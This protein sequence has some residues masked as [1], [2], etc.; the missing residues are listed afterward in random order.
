MIPTGYPVPFGGVR[1]DGTEHE[2]CERCGF[3]SRA[4]RRQD[5]SALFSR[6][7]HWWRLATRACSV[8]ELNQRPAPQVWSA[9]E[10]GLHSAMVLPILRGAIEVMLA[11]DRADVH[12]PWPEV[13][14]EDAT[15]PLTLDP[16]PLLDDL[17]REG[18]LFSRLVD[19]SQRGWGHLGH[20]D[21]GTWWQAE[22]TL[23]HA[24]HD[25]THH[26]LDVLEGLERIRAGVEERC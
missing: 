1:F 24:V 2:I 7:G 16:T 3:D 10:Y 6:L 5:A 22:A 11:H 26:L 8:D 19:N 14:I 4:W 20:M 17:E 23:L 9:L 25:T 15:Q 21:D 12:D 18:L 13:D